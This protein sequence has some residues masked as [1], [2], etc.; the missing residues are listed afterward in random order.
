M[1][2]TYPLKTLFA[3]CLLAVALLFSCSDQED[4]FEMEDLTSLYES[5]DLLIAAIANA[6]NK[7]SVDISALP[8]DAKNTLQTDYNSMM[9]KQSFE[10]EKL[11]YEVS[12]IGLEPVNLAEEENT[13]FDQDG[14]EL[15]PGYDKRDPRNAGEKEGDRKGK[16]RIHFELVYPV[17]FT[18]P[19]G[20]VISVD[21][22]QDFRAQVKSWF[23]AHPDSE[24]KPLLN[25]PVE[26][27]VE[28]VEEAI[29]INNEEEMK[30]LKRRLRKEANEK[31]K[32]FEFVFPL[33][34][35]M[36]DGTTLTAQSEEELKE[37]IG[38]WYEANPDTEERPQLV[39]PVELLLEDGEMITINSEEEMKEF[40]ERIREGHHGHHGRP[41]EFVFPLSFTMPDGSTIVGNN[42]EELE[43]LI[44]SWYAANPESEEK[45]TL[46]FPVDLKLKDGEIITINS[47]EEMRAFLERIREG[48][49][50]YHGRPFEFV[51]PISFTMPDG[52]IITGNS[53]EEIEI[54]IKAWYEANPE[55]EEKPALVFPVD[56]EL[57]DGEIITIN[58]K[59][60]MKAF[61][62]S[63][64]EHIYGD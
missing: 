17:S 27:L 56:L 6:S 31:D 35:I 7:N 64:L 5:D 12:M 37:L 30:A 8:T 23:E 50:G 57:K 60:E 29:P 51:Y 22:K 24:G 20:T 63:I 40:R 25:Y 47:K 46:V 43:T 62:E 26:V 1:K 48:Q 15:I 16:R 41:F 53:K 38:A 11:G 34:F 36:P 19:D 18:M 45:P 39:Y 10:V 52:L 28:G 21:N 33:S 13:Y 59:E 4:A 61:L 58:S 42:K 54:L 44:K 2:S 9:A 3:S 49:H 55:S 14:R 32:P